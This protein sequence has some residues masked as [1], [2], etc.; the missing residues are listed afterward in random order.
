MRSLPAAARPVTDAPHE[1]A[2]GP[3]SWWIALVLVVAA[4]LRLRLALRSPLWFEELYFVLAAR[5]TAA[6]VWAIA[7]NDIHP[8]VGFMLR[9][10]WT[11]L[12][13][14]GALWHKSL[15]M[16][17]ALAC[18]PVAWALVRRLFGAGAALIATA[19]MAVTFALVRYGQEVGNHSLLWL[20]A[21]LAVERWTAFHAGGRTRD[22]VVAAALTVL[23]TYTHYAVIALEVV[24]FAWGLVTLAGSR[25]RAGRWLALHALVAVAFLPQLPVFL[26]QIGREATLRYAL[27]PT[28]H[29]ARLFAHWLCLE[30]RPTLWAFPVLALL[31]LLDRA[32]RRAAAWMWVL[33]LVPPLFVRVLPITFPNEFLF[34]APFWFALVA[35]G[36]MG[37]PWRSVRAAVAV[38]AVLAG[39]TLSAPARPFHEPIALRA[40]FARLAAV[41][42]PG[43]EVIH[44]E[45][46]S[47]MFAL[48]YDPAGRHRLLLENGGA[49]Y[50]DG[51]LVIPDSLRLDPRQ[52][53]AERA[54]GAP[55][56][57][58]SV[59]RARVLRYRETRAGAAQLATIREAAHGR[60]WVF[61]PVTL[62]EGVPP[63]R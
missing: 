31:P 21:V 19:L 22:G 9:W 16:L 30:R 12:G 57:A 26:G 14:D 10:A 6:E 40:A 58:I 18:I 42:H 27:F 55:W 24:V 4:A 52:W 38:L 5:R 11:R 41:R 3:R 51:G 17:F 43:D 13:G 23:G 29:D 36:V 33:V 44:A 15:S 8:P 45:S 47:L 39:L 61:P 32:R 63:A 2:A 62:W 54:T 20:L 28:P 56:W 37:L 25:L 35:S 1:P 7:A 53:A 48:Y 34:A 49:S 50:F 46:H 60:R 59:D